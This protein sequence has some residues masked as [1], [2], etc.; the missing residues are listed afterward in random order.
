MEVGGMEEGGPIANDDI[1]FLRTSGKE[2][3]VVI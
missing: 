1:M 3:T 2:S